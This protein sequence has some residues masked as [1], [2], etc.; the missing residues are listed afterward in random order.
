[1]KAR[2]I[3]FYLI[4]STWAL[5]PLAEAQDKQELKEFLIE[6]ESYFFFEEYTEALPLLHRI[7]TRD[8]ENYNVLYKIGIC[9]LNDPYQKNRSISYLHRASEQVN[10]DYKVNSY[11]ERMAPP[12]V[13]FFLG[14]AY[15]VSGDIDKALQHLNN[16]LEKHNPSI[17]DTQVILDEIASC[18]RAKQAVKSPIYMAKSSF[19]PIVNT[20]FAESNP[21]LSGDGTTLIFNRKLQFYNAVFIVSKKDDGS[22][23]V[24]YNLTSDFGLDGDSYAT[25]ISYNGDRIFVYRSDDFDGNIYSSS[26]VDGKWQKLEK[27]GGNIN[28]KFWESHA[29][30]SPD[31]KHLF[32]TSNRTGGYGGLDIYRSPKL[33]TGEWGEPENIGPIVNSPLNEDSPFLST[34]GEKL[35]FSSTGHNSIGGYDL[36]VSIRKDTNEWSRPINMGYPLS[37]NDDDMFFCPIE[38]NKYSGVYS[39]YDPLSTVGLKD[40]YY[41]EIYNEVFPRMYKLKGKLNSSIPGFFEDNQ[42]YFALVGSDGITVQTKQVG[43]KGEFTLEANHGIYQLRIYGNTIEP[44]ILPIELPVNLKG[45]L[46]EIPEVNVVES[47]SQPDTTMFKKMQA[48]NLELLSPELV[49]TDSVPLSIKLKLEKGANLHV[50]YII[51]NNLEHEKEFLV[52]QEEFTLEYVPKDGNNLLIFKVEGEDG[53][54]ATKEVT[55]VYSPKVEKDVLTPDTLTTKFESIAQ[56]APTGLREYLLSLEQLS[57][58]SLSDLYAM[59]RANASVNEY[60]IASVDRLFEKLLSQRPMNEFLV[61]VEKQAQIGQKTIRDSLSGVTDMPLSWVVEGKKI[62]IITKVQFDYDLLNIVPYETGETDKLSY[63]HSFVGQKGETL[64]GKYSGLHKPMNI[65]SALL[66]EIGGELTEELVNLASTT[67]ALNRYYNRLLT[68]PN[69]ELRNILNDVELNSLEIKN[70]IQLNNYLFEK[71]DSLG[72]DKTKLIYS[73]EQSKKGY[74]SALSKFLESMASI[75]QGDLKLRIEELDISKNDIRSFEEIIKL[76]LRD[77]TSRAYSAQEV[78]NLLIKMIGIGNVDTFIEALLEKSDG[79]LYNALMEMDRQQ[80]TNEIEV[81]KYLLS[82]SGEYDY[83]DSY[84]N[85]LLIRMLLE[86]GMDSWDKALD[87]SFAKKIIRKRSLLTSSILIGLFVIIL[88]FFRRKRKKE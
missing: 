23:K 7:L 42:V 49:I 13:E 54:I 10:P 53:L 79:K 56:F 59:L 86:S 30:P 68:S 82:K 29:S 12:E 24:P 17:F 2:F 76:L 64:A 84:I 77:A 28:T 58:S 1:M 43:S 57:F 14:Q 80:Y 48:P 25:G 87:E 66:A 74:G 31:G 75:A 27:L 85:N 16:F 45:W 32:F 9:Y 37:T 73:I 3:F 83:T 15:H 44:Q 20:R 19:E 18:K 40:I 63:L 22:W 61:E 47:V 46:V 60:E 4:I 38:G 81:I 51:N 50:Q 55:I 69:S 6:A 5:V 8:P 39:M 11:K 65:Y 41:L 67:M 26:K 34:D 88:V 71:Y 62:A 35:F 36:F 72:L 21:V 33:N 70:S 78:Y 52:Q